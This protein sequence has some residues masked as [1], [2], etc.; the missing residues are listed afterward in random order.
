MVKENHIQIRVS[1]EEKEDIKD[2][3]KKHGFDDVSSFI[4]WL[5]RK[6]GR[7]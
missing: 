7:G 4:L 3:A 2:Q 5:F 6:F 1:D